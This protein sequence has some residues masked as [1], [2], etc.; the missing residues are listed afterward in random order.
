[1]TGVMMAAGGNVLE[2]YDFALYGMLAPHIAHAFFPEKTH[3]I[4]LLITFGVFAAGFLMRPLGGIIYGHF[5]DTRSRKRA[6]VSSCLLIM[7]PTFLLGI[8]PSSNQIGIV[9]PILVI[10]IRLFQGL[11]IGGEFTGTISYMGEV[12]VPGTKNFFASFSMASI[13][14]GLLLANL[15]VT[16]VIHTC[17]QAAFAAWAWR[18]PFVAS[19]ILGCFVYLLRRNMPDVKLDTT[20]LKNKFPLVIAFRDYWYNMLQAFAVTILIGGGF[21]MIVVYTTTYNHEVLHVSLTATYLL[22]LVIVITCMIS[23]PLFGKLADKIGNRTVLIFAAIIFILIAMPLNILAI[24]QKQNDFWHLL[25]IVFDLSLLLSMYLGASP[26]LL[27]ECLPKHVRYSGLSFSY[28]LGIAVVGGL[29]PMVVTY[30]IGKEHFFSILGLV[31]LV[32]AVISL[33]ALLSIRKKDIHPSN[34]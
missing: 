5:G 10:A 28:N 3:W 17:G 18:L 21:W 14:V 6:L 26:G 27:T 34:E 23:I 4:S 11:A 12:A 32:A 22:N 30:Y 16:S 1:M 20:R 13:M 29:S 33:I 9:A 25:N 19:I 24:K 8:V 2:W 31:Q 7:V 15:I